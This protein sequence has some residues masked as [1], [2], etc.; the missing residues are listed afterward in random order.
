M[1]RTAEPDELDDPGST[2][3]TATDP[4]AEPSR[5]AQL[6]LVVIGDATLTSH[7]VPDSATVTIGRSPS[8]DILINDNSISRKH[9]VL[10]IGDRDHLRIEDLGSA[11]GTTVRGRKLEHSRPTQ[12]AIGEVVSL[13]SVKIMLQPKSRRTCGRV[14][15]HAAFLDSV[16][17]H[18]RVAEQAGTGFALLRIHTDRRASAPL[19]EE[20]LGQSLRESDILAKFGPHEYEVLMPGTPEGQADAAARRLDGQLLERGLRCRMFV[21]CYPRDGTIAKELLARVHA[22]EPAARVP[23]PGDIVVSDPLM[24]GVLRTLDQ[25]ASSNIGVL[26]RGET[27]TGK[28]VFAH[29][30]HRASTRAS[31]PF[32]AVNCAA[33][34]ETLFESELFG[35]EKGAF[36]HAHAA[37]V[38]L[39]ETAHGGTLLLDEVGD[40]PLSIQ[41]K[42]L[43]FLEDS[44]VRRVGGVKS[45]A[46]D[47]RVVAATN[48]DLEEHIA[49]GT[50]RRDLFYRLNGITIVLPALRDRP[51]ELEPMARAFIARS[52]NRTDAAPPALVRDALDALLAYPWPGNV[53]E[54]KH[55][56][57]RA[58]LL[59]GGGPIQ[60]EHL[61][62]EPVAVPASPSRRAADTERTEP[63]ETL[64]RE[65]GEDEQQWIL[66]G[67]ERAG[68][69]QTRAAR[70]LGLS[71]RTLVSRLGEYQ[72]ERPRK[73][74]LKPLDEG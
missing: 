42:L 44:Q 43:R 25:V 71:R 9:A 68:G 22:P 6:Q 30:L 40:M 52:W 11:N 24:H 62:L 7:R 13:G 1:G 37:K 70:L 19:L 4:L 10:A 16:D 12:I 35:H 53:R 56:I 8:C 45:H 27:G 31:G 50:F 33:L 66:R 72:I 64:G 63:I 26:F 60:P 14:G 74:K 49:R 17:E 61:Q 57:A 55:V 58:V 23:V 73:L 20:T 32:V 38:G 48:I 29:A 28:E 34:T 47:V 54:L 67:L 65:K 59:C 69:N 41:V 5:P 36:T 39:L 51:A 3:L 21:A 18:C 46:I 2:V 15:S